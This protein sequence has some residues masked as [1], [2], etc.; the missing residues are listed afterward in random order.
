MSPFEVELNPQMTIL[1]R[2]NTT[3]KK[4]KQTNKQT[5]TQQHY[6]KSAKICFGEFVLQTFKSSTYSSFEEEN[7]QN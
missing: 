5:K 1:V 7:S 3:K 2:T 4:N 6:P